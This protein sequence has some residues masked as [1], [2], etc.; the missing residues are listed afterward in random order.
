MSETQTPMIQKIRAF[1]TKN[2]IINII[3]LAFFITAFVLAGIST[4]NSEDKRWGI[5]ILSILGLALIIIQVIFFKKLK[6]IYDALV[7]SIS[8]VGGGIQKGLHYTRSGA[9]SV[10]NVLTGTCHANKINTK[11]S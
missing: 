9:S 2:V 11:P 8:Y 1:F 4:E 7:N 6:E 3:G 5:S 10:G